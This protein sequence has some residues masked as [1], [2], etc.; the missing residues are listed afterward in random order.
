VGTA[1]GF[2]LRIPTADHLIVVVPGVPAELRAMVE[3]SVVPLLRSHPG[4]GPAPLLG[5]VTVAGI[6]EVDLGSR[7]EDLMERGRDPIVGS[8][9]KL[10]RVV[11]TVE[12]RAPADEAALRVET[13]LAEIE[14]R[15]GDAVVGRGDLLLNEVVGGL[16]LARGTTIAIAESL[17]GGL[18]ADGL[19]AVPGISRV[20]L[21]GWVAYANRTKVE[22]LGVPQQVLDSDG[23]VSE[24]C[25]RAMAAGA[26][27]RS[28]AALA[29]A[30]S[31][32]AGPDGGSSE[33]PVGT[34]WFAISDGAGE[35]TNRAV[36]PGDRAAV[37]AY[38]CARAFDLMR[39]RLLGLPPVPAAPAAAS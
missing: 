12:S 37:R 9:P 16:L 13:T 39:R 33:K 31:G 35:V 32:I 28:G 3:D 4:R 7:I 8:Y 6:R 23:A 21:A 10:G 22:E 14:R 30:L 5:S 25:V 2:L 27:A 26:R 36:F 38:A 19:V 11:L 18:V 1:P 34:V 17:T 29:L 20:F 15:I 24:A